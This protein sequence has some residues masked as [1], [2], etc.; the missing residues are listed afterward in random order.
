[1]N[2]VTWEE[3]L[4]ELGEVKPLVGGVFHSSIVEVKAIYVDIC[5]HHPPLD[6]KQRS[7][8]D[9]LGPA[10]EATGVVRILS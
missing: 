8:S 6:I 7:P 2:L 5:P 3:S 1:M 4:A 10:A 9:D